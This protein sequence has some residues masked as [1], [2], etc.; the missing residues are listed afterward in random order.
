[1]KPEDFVHLHVHSHY[2]LLDG[3][4]TPEALVLRAK[5]L[6]MTALALTDHG[7]MYGAVEFYKDC[8]KNDIKPIIGMET[9]VAP[10]GLADKVSKL[11][12]TPYH[13]TLWAK[14]PEGY[15]NL[16]KLTSIAHLE[17]YYYRPRVDK[18]TLKKYSK[19]LIAGSGCLIGEIP[20]HLLSKDT[21]QAQA[22][23][24]EY[25]E[26]FGADSFYLEL[27]D[28]PEI[29]DQGT[30]N[31]AIIKLA[32][33]TNTPLIVTNDTHYINKDDREA[34][35]V[36]ICVQTGK[37]VDDPKRMTYDGD[38]SLRD[39]KELSRVFHNVPE[40]LENTRKIADRCNLEIAFEENL[41]PNFPIPKG[42]T[43]EG[44]LRELCEQ[45]MKERYD[46]LG[47]KEKEELKTR[48]D[49]ELGT[50]THMGFARY[51]LVVSDFV[52]WAKEKGILVGPGRGSAAGSLVSYLI[53]ITDIDPLHYGLLFERFLNP[54][55]IEMPDI[56]MDFADHRRSEVLGH[57]LSK[58]GDDKVAGIIT[59]GTMAARAAV[60][61]VGRALGMPY[62]EVDAIAKILPPPVQGRHIPLEKSVR[63]AVELR[64]V[65][66]KEPRTKRLLDMAM[67]LEG[68]VRH[69]SQHAS[70]FVITPAPLT[71]FVPLQLAQKEGVKQ[72]TQY[73]MYPVAELGLLKM[74]F[75]GLANL[76]IIERALEIIEAVHKQKIDIHRLPL[77]DRK[78]F[79][80]LGRAE[81][82]GVFQLESSGMKR[83]VKELKPNSVDDVAVMVALYR[84]GPIQFI[85]SFIARKNEKEA[86]VFPHPKTETALEVTYGI[87]VYQEQV[88]QIAK[89][90]AGFTG[91]EADTLRKAMGKKIA[92]L[93]AEMKTKF[94]AG[95][96]K[97]GIPTRQSEK[98]FSMLEDFAQYGF[99]KSHAVCYAMIA[100]QT[101]YLK[102]H[103]PECFMAALLTSDLN[104]IDRI[105]IEI[106]EC[107]RMGIKVLP[108]DVNESFVDF[109][110]VKETGNIRFGLAA[111]KNIGEVPARVIVRERKKNGPYKSFEDFV[112]RLCKTDVEGSGERLILNKKVLEALSQSGA[113]DNMAE[114]NQILL[115]IDTVLKRI[116]DTS[117]QIKSSQIG[118]F[119]EVLSSGI[120]LGK[121]ELPEVEPAS[122]KERLQ[123]EKTLLGIYLSEHPL[124]EYGGALRAVTTH[125]IGALN[126]DME[127]KRVKIGG[128][129]GPIK[130]ISTRNGQPMLFAGIEDLSGKSEVLVFPKLLET[131]PEVWAND[132]LVLVEGKISTKDNAVKILADKAE[133]FDPDKVDPKLAKKMGEHMV[134]VGVD[135]DEIVE[136]DLE[137]E[138][139][140][141]S[142]SDVAE[143]RFKKKDFAFEYKE[144]LIVLLPN[145]TTKEKL[146]E[147]KE[148]LES[149]RG[150]MPVVL[151]HKKNGD[152]TFKKTK[153][154][155]ELTAK[156]INQLKAV[157]SK[158]VV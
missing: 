88:M 46:G 61:D 140:I 109:G 80:L 74:D 142:L 38:F 97:R 16:M 5:E 67:K 112:D 118:L 6:G 45:G 82:T 18:E 153:L 19:G 101:A 83:Y 156:L 60:R 17:G 143:E 31:N 105:A 130:K 39:P 91:G 50:I 41:L 51:F 32:K 115:G 8:K 133:R 148:I 2:S 49:F 125:E 33:K 107:E 54:D 98:V 36:L 131:I 48:L 12:S 22:A 119:G 3:L 87:P 27:Q 34:H 126:L 44:Y 23:L 11:D 152:F 65:Y 53:G 55:R 43:A 10:R 70:A 47:K 21:K 111:I 151:A 85:D 144:E 29:R 158:T 92:K 128:I 42:K 71:D 7:A 26:I 69:A 102:A 103:F 25:R 73:S 13:L 155:V 157:F 64:D 114:R 56:D 139:E 63:D 93:M 147:I 89:D 123:W 75:L 86:V 113:L 76:T 127:G 96:L 1:M 24:K 94:I 121:L 90:M 132:S 154:T 110:V 117:K 120:E 122:Q 116:Q 81:T 146:L 106:A 136:I 72:I 57:V 14:N 59:F 134:T 40:A 37:T 4:G 62:A 84:P 15:R 99:N 30:A 35:D 100:Y 138:P 124:R 129:L 150:Q 104:D 141:E 145:D 95:C 28:H 66:E 78:T 135:E 68:T 137:E 58:Y 9:Y 79:Q 52:G 20:R 108:P 77:D 149:A